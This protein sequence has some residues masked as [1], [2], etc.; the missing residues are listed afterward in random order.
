MLRRA[1]L[2]SAAAGCDQCELLPSFTFSY[3]QLGAAAELQKCVRAAPAASMC[4]GWVAPLVPA[5]RWGRRRVPFVERWAQ[6]PRIAAAAGGVGAGQH[7]SC[8]MPAGSCAP[9]KGTAWGTPREKW[10]LCWVPRASGPGNGSSLLPS[11]EAQPPASFWGPCGTAVAFW[12]PSDLGTS[13]GTP[14]PCS[15]T[16]G[17]AGVLCRLTTNRPKAAGVACSTVGPCPALAALRPALC[18]GVQPSLPP[19]LGMHSW[20]HAMMRRLLRPLPGQ[21][22]LC[23]NNTNQLAGKSKLGTLIIR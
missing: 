1:V 4:F 6:N 9:G 10:P 20:C 22:L 14:P 23:V 21:L 19:A 8:A 3:G 18:R 2:C 13:L 17:F 12:G 11:S 5:C 15:R 7:C 16:V